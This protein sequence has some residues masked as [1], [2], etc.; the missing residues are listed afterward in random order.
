MKTK[1]R[2]LERKLRDKAELLRVLAHP[3]RLL[4]IQKLA[5][6][7]K[8]VTDIQDLLD[9]AQANLSQHL[10]V[11]RSQDI[12]DY[13]EDGKLRCYYLTRPAIA[14]LV[15]EILRSTYPIV[16]RSQEDVRRAGSRRKDECSG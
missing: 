16:E 8:C 15:K 12:V 9:V 11:L 7:P 1:R 5:K 6:G 4:I 14:C 10:A 13:H 2:S 3:T